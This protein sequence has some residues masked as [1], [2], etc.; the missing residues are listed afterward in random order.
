VNIRMPQNKK[1]DE[2]SDD[3][4][5]ILSVRDDSI[6]GYTDVID[7]ICHRRFPYIELLLR[8]RAFTPGRYRI[9]NGFTKRLTDDEVDIV[10]CEQVLWIQLTNEQAQQI[11]G[12]D[13]PPIFG[14]YVRDL[15][16]YFSKHD[17]AYANAP[18]MNLHVL[19]HV[20]KPVQ[21][22]VW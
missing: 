4:E 11:L 1:S 10:S 2:K 19:R 15:R 16:R 21:T 13:K 5:N 6:Y 17:M 7:K 20:K 22:T 8:R 12:T 14:N 18:V 3:E 9:R